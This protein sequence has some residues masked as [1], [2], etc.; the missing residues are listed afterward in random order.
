ML[1][2]EHSF[3]AVNKVHRCKEAADSEPYSVQYLQCINLTSIPPS[4]QRLQIGVPLILIWN[5]YLKDLD[6]LRE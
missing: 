4:C 2:T 5:V 1:D 6:Q 3:E